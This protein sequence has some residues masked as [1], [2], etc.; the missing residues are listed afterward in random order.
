VGSKIPEELVPFW[1][2]DFCSFHSPEWWREHWEK[3]GKVHVTLAD[4]IVDGWKDWLRF[5]EIKLPLTPERWQKAGSDEVAMLQ[6]DKGEHLG[7][8]RVVATK[9]KLQA[10]PSGSP[11][12]IGP[13]AQRDSSVDRAVRDGERNEG[14]HRNETEAVDLSS[15]LGKW[16]TDGYVLLPGFLSAVQMEPGIAELGRL[17]PM[18]D[19]FHDAPDEQQYDRFRDEF[20]GIDDS[21]STARN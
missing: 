1:H 14:G 9:A 3:T 20:G 21:H 17:F 7:F 10:R 11:V 6:I 2:W 18:A 8:S 13:P 12:D 5:G 16:Q 15:S 19:E 4:S